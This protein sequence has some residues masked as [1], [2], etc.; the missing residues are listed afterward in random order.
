LTLKLEVARTCD[1]A[2]WNE[3]VRGVGG[4]VSHSAEWARYT[5]AAQPHVEPLYFRLVEPDGRVAGVALGFR[6]RSPSKVL[7]SLS[8]LLRFE[9]FPATRPDGD[10]A[11]RATFLRE[12]EE[13]ARRDGD[14]EID[15]GTFIYRGGTPELE[16][17]GYELRRR[18]EFETDIQRDDDQLWLAIPKKRRK[19]ITKG[20]RS[21]VVVDVPE[22]EDGLRELRRLQEI[23]RERI[24]ERGGPDVGRRSGDANDP[25]L[26]LLHAN[27]AKVVTA[28]VGGEVVSAHFFTV[29]NGTVYNMLAAHA[30][31]AF[32]AEAPSLLLWESFRHFRDE[33]A[34]TFNLGGCGADATEPGSAEHGVYNYKRRFKFETLECAS[35]HKV[36]R[37]LAHGVRGVL[38]KALGRA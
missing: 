9:S 37:R 15:V 22:P 31:A 36:L 35:G 25:L 20:R 34:T 10:A 21:D 23:T 2:A 38:K 29:F 19:D 11:L 12:I 28:A 3:E 18:I 33:G 16:A 8:G 14:V 26:V 30:P 1:E 24:L 27:V 7:A 4:T 32:P 13:Q 17:A 6:E 5:L